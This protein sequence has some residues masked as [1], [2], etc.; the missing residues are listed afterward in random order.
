MH[1]H[2][3]SE[4]TLHL[5]SDQ[6]NVILRDRGGADVSAGPAPVSRGTWTRTS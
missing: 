5:E 6:L 3:S 1:A 4:L 2:A